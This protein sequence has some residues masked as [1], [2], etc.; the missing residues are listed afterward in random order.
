M[1]DFNVSR[2]VALLGVLINN[3][4]RKKT[5]LDPSRMTLLYF[6]VVGIAACGGMDSVSDDTK[7]RII[8]WV[9][10]MQISNDEGGGGFKM[11][12]NLQDGHI[13]AAQCGLLVLMLCGDDLSRV[14][15]E[16]LGSFLKSIQT[17][18]GSFRCTTYGESDARF[19]Y[20]AMIVCEVLSLWDYINKDSAIQ[21]ALGNQR[22]DGGFAGNPY[23]ESHGGNTFCCIAS[24]VLLQAD[25]LINK[26]RALRWLT[27]RLMPDSGFNGRPNKASDTCYNYWVGVSIKLLTDPKL[28][29]QITT[30][31][32]KSFTQACECET[33]GIAKDE[34]SFID[35]LHTTLPL[36]GLNNLGVLKDMPELDPRLGCP[37]SVIDSY[38]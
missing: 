11:S 10:H 23:E 3:G 14:N 9:Y 32:I 2:H 12:P 1:S 5:S 21:Y 15:R 33:G 18:E 4:F 26:K 24:L 34:E 22:Y 35:L 29:P 7:K 16:G 20:S 6:S 31:S 37:K 27:S 25:H 19:L 36:L 8:D 13:T 17:E 38:L 30:S 28:F